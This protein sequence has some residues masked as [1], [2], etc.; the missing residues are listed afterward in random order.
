MLALPPNILVHH[1]SNPDFTP[2]TSRDVMLPQNTPPATCLPRVKGA[3]PLLFVKENGR[4]DTVVCDARALVRIHK[5]AL[6]LW[7]V[8]APHKIWFGKHM[9][10]NPNPVHS[11]HPLK[12]TFITELHA[13]LSLYLS[14]NTYFRPKFIMSADSLDDLSGSQSMLHLGTSYSCLDSCDLTPKFEWIELSLLPAQQLLFFHKRITPTSNLQH[15]RQVRSRS[16]RCLLSPSTHPAH[17]PTSHTAPHGNVLRTAGGAN[18]HGEANS[19]SKD[20]DAG[21]VL[22]II[23]RLGPHQQ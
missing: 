18:F 23:R 12:N 17:S 14:L 3:A 20:P 8:H 11:C 9:M 4:T 13:V 16:C 15:G 1:C 21:A 7:K 22:L 5:Y 19:P 6:K 10:C 2:T